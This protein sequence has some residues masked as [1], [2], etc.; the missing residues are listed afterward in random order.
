MEYDT[1]KLRKKCSVKKIIFIKFANN[2]VIKNNADILRHFITTEICTYSFSVLSFAWSLESLQPYGKCSKIWLS[3][4]YRLY[5]VIA[6][7]KVPLSV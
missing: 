4:V 1:E 5:V 6:S 7:N 3:L 2:I